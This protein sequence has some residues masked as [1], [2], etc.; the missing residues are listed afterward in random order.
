MASTYEKA[1]C[2]FFLISKINFILL[3]ENTQS[4]KATDEKP[5]KKCCTKIHTSPIIKLQIRIHS[6]LLYSNAPNRQ[7]NHLSLFKLCE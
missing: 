7:M 6:N 4:L 2:S 3:S 1:S 5:H